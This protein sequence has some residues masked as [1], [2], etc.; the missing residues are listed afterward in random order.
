MTP[1]IPIDAWP[2]RLEAALGRSGDAAAH[3]GEELAR[4]I[5]V[6]EVGSTQDEAR[7]RGARVGDVIVAWRQTKGRGRFGRA[8][9]DTG[10]DGVALSVV[11][12]D[13]RADQAIMRVSVAVAAALDRAVTRDGR[14]T[15]D[16][17]DSSDARESSDMRESSDARD[18]SDASH[19]RDARERRPPISFGIKWPNDILE[20]GG[21]KVAGILIERVE[22][23]LVV[24]IGVNVTQHAF[25]AA[26]APRAR[27]LRMLGFECDRLDVVARVLEELARGLRADDAAVRDEY[28]RRDVLRGTHA[29][30]T[31]AGRF[32]EGVVVDVDPAHGIRVR[33]AEGEQILPA[34]VTTLAVEAGGFEST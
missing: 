31:S 21:G 7:A 9:V 25:D 3:D 8:W 14:E 32:V 34:A 5:V 13:R 19:A 33:T 28:R 22:G 20:P 17:R 29:R 15:R 24:G 16:G 2:G 26:L 4:A 18:S 23:R 12:R 27:S 6:D 30:F 11:L 1:R 10:E